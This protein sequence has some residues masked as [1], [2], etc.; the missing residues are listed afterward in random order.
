MA[1]C[2]DDDVHATRHAAGADH[3]TLADLERLVRLQEILGDPRTRVEVS[4]TSSESQPE[5]LPTSN[6]FGFGV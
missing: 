6:R 3:A 2:P 4:H 1:M 5:E